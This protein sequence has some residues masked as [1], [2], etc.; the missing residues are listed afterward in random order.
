MHSIGDFFIRLS[1]RKFLLTIT[2]IILVTLYPEGATYICTLIGIF[3]GGEGVADTVSRYA[4]EK[5]KQ[6]NILDTP[7]VRQRA[8]QVALDEEED[9]DLTQIVAGDVPL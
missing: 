9:I 7:A 4:V 5:T 3:V 2:G 6:A 1:S 8:Q